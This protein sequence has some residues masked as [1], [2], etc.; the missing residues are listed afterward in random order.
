[1]NRA[2]VATVGL[3]A[4]ILF[5]V[6]IAAIVPYN[7]SKEVVKPTENTTKTTTKTT[8]VCIAIVGCNSTNK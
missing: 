2:D 7:S 8:T 5:L 6:F 1:M 3:G 4:V